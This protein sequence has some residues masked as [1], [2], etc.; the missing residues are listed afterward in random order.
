MIY[1]VDNK[2]YNFVL[3]MVDQIFLVNSILIDNIKTFDI[4]YMDTTIF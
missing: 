1:L 4:K 2:V 3:Y